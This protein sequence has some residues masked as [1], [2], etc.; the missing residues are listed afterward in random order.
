[1]A[2]LFVGASCASTCDLA[3][4][5][6]PS[7]TALACVRVDPVFATAVAAINVGA[8]V[9][10]V[11]AICSIPSDVADTFTGNAFTVAAFLR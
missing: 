3:I 4:I 5:T 11:L 2:R 10:I 6:F 1:M 7:G 9:D 8:V